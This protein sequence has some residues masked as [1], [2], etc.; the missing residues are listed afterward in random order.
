MDDMYITMC[1]HKTQIKLLEEWFDD[2]FNKGNT[3]RMYVI[4]EVIIN[5]EG[6]RIESISSDQAIKEFG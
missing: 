6:R 2:E 3:H 5:M 1:N 4:N